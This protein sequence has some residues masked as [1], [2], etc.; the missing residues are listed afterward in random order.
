[1]ALSASVL[2]PAIRVAL[3]ANPDIQ[4]IDGD[5]LTALSDAIAGAVVDHIAAAA[6]VTIPPGVPVSTAGTAVAQTGA[7][8]APAIGAVT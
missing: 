3:L 8:T 6:V 2:G 7:T 1:M 5:A 4:A